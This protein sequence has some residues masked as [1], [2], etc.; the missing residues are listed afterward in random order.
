[1]LKKSK[2]Q[3]DEEEGLKRRNNRGF[4]EEVFEREC[5]NIRS[6]MKQQNEDECFAF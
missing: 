1:M 2:N 6:L 4:F 3:D 5:E